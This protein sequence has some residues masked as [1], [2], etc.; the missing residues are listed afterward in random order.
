MPR[1]GPP[2]VPPTN[3][4]LEVVRPATDIVGF[5]PGLLVDHPQTQRCL[6]NPLPLLDGPAPPSIVGPLKAL[7]PWELTFPPI[8]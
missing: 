6:K 7:A 8:L 5:R 3:L 1:S 2:L 4:E